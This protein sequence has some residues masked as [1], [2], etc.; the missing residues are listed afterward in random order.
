MK[1]ELILNQRQIV[2]SLPRN[3]YS[4]GDTVVGRVFELEGRSVDVLLWFQFIHQDEKKIKP[5]SIKGKWPIELIE[6]EK[7]GE[8]TF[9]L[10]LGLNFFVSSPS[11]SFYLQLESPIE[12][13]SS[14]LQLITTPFTLYQ[15]IV[16]VFERIYRFKLKKSYSTP[17]GPKALKAVRSAIKLDEF[18]LGINYEFKSP[19]GKDFGNCSELEITLKRDH[20]AVHFFIN[21]SWTK[22]EF[23]GSSMSTKKVK[24]TLNQSWPL[25]KI[26]VQGKHFDHLWV[27][28]SWA[29]LLAEL[30]EKII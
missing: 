30:K 20:E 15:N 1:T 23:L 16:E 11:D 2:L 12:S 7:K 26:L 29:T 19:E 10:S 8:F 4:Q 5:A 13:K 17:P 14:T 27:Q 9:S 28:N 3:N 22:I 6:G 24:K 25:S 21:S 18:E